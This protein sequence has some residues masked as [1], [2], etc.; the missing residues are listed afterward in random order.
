MVSVRYLPQQKA[1]GGRYGLY[2]TP[3]PIQ[4]PGGLELGQAAANA[5]LAD[6][7]RLGDGSP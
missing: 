2:C 1:P 5:A 7:G 4:H 3:Q 6:A